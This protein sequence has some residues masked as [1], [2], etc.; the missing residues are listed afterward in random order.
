[1][2]LVAIG[3]LAIAVILW[4]CVQLWNSPDPHHDQFVSLLPLLDLE[5]SVG[6]PRPDPQFDPPRVTQ[7]KAVASKAS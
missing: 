6:T 5:H 7:S 4:A 2:S 3:L 1:M